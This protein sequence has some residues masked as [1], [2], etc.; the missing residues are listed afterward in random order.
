MV[1][2]AKNAFIDVASD[3]L[4]KY[5]ES[6]DEDDLYRANYWRQKALLDWSAIA[7]NVDVLEGRAKQNGHEHHLSP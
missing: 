7:D 2:V 4:K 1:S 3:H 5:E 6:N